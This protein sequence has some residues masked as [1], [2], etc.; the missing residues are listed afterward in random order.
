MILKEVILVVKKSRTGSHRQNAAAERTVNLNVVQLYHS[1]LYSFPSIWASAIPVEIICIALKKF[2]MVE[3]VVKASLRMELM[4]RLR[5]GQKFAIN[6]HPTNKYLS[7]VHYHSHSDSKIRITVPA[8]RICQRRSQFLRTRAY[9]LQGCGIS[10]D[11]VFCE[12][13]MRSS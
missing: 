5:L 10:S 3:P 12:F 4:V 9:R 11:V 8:R 6:Q 13:L 7:E 2:V 1:V